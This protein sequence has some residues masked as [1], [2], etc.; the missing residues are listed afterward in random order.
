MKF[1]VRIKANLKAIE[2]LRQTQGGKVRAGWERESDVLHA[3]INEFGA[4]LKG[5]QPFFID[6]KGDIH[7]LKKTSPLGI[8][9]MRAAAGNSPKTPSKPKPGRIQGLGVTRPSE[10]PPRPFISETVRLHRKEW[11]QLY[12]T[13]IMAVANG[14]MSEEHAMDAL[15]LRIAADLKMTIS[16]GNFKP[17]STLTVKAKGKNTPLIW[18]G[19]MQDHVAHEVIMGAAK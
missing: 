17:N 18:T 7:F 12:K 15:G 14:I 9:A 16:E 4:H 1:S 13:L 11:E 3:I 19:D 8:K 6:D 10:I 2:R 5:G